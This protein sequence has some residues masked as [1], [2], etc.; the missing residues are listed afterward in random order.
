MPQWQ[1]VSTDDERDA[2]RAVSG[3]SN[4]H[5]EKPFTVQ[6]TPRWCLKTTK[7]AS[8]VGRGSTWGKS[9]GSIPWTTSTSQNVA[10][11]KVPAASS[12]AMSSDYAQTYAQRKLAVSQHLK[13]QAKA[14]QCSKQQASKRWGDGTGST[15]WPKRQTSAQHKHKHRHDDSDDASIA[16]ARIKT[17]EQKFM[18]KRRQAP[19][20]EPWGTGP[21]L[22]KPPDSPTQQTVD[23]EYD[24]DGCLNISTALSKKK[25]DAAAHAHAQKIRLGEQQRTFS[26]VKGGD[27]S[28]WWGLPPARPRARRTT[29]YSLTREPI[30]AHDVLERTLKSAR[31]D[32]KRRMGRLRCRYCGAEPPNDNDKVA[33]LRHEARCFRAHGLG[34][35]NEA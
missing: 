30:D 9:T 26:Q 32:V 14:Q 34:Y 20:R 6:V 16:I 25:R 15:R 11:K 1:V 21:R 19:S 29:Y 28:V 2:L 31:N 27:R 24:S 8:D 17:S 23:L 33:L 4:L 35:F 3:E 12:H 18:R 10:T 13:R 22:N 5:R 7:K